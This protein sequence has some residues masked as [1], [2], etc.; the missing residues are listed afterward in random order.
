MVHRQ[1]A[2]SPKVHL[3]FWKYFLNSS[4]AKVVNF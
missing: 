1:Y 3:E 4:V 2:F